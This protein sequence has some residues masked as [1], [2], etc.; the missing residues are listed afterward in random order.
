MNPKLK[1]GILGLGNMGLP[2]YDSLVSHYAVSPFDPGLIEKYPNIPFANSLSE[3]DHSCS[4]I[5][6]AVKPDKITHILGQFKS[7]KTFLS[8]AAGIPLD[9]LETHAPKESICVRLMPNLPLLIGEGVIGMYGN[10]KGYALTRELFSNLGL[11]FEVNKEEHIDAITG[12][13]GSGPAYVFSFVQALAEGGVLSGLSY[14]DSLNLT[15]QTLKGSVLYLENQRQTNPHCHPSELRN[16]VTSPGGTTIFG[17]N[18]LESSG[19]HSGVMK[20]VYAAFQRA[21][22]LGKK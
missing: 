17:L 8:I 12:L 20:A 4:I 1:I 22:E 2:I 9:T 5:I 7:P 14:T 10:P 16:K 21:R 6:L 15:I 13:S 19:F 11:I 18:E 3:I